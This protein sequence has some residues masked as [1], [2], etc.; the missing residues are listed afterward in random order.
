MMELPSDKSN[1]KQKKMTNN[2][3]KGQIL[4]FLTVS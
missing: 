1:L 3:K 4:K 2:T